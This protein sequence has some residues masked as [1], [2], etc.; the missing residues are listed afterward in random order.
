M[1]KQEFDTEQSD[2]C[3]TAAYQPCTLRP[4]SI[5]SLRRLEILPAYPLAKNDKTRRVLLLLSN[6]LNVNRNQ[7]ES[8][9]H[10]FCPFEFKEHR[11]VEAVDSFMIDLYRDLFI[12]PSQQWKI[13][14]SLIDYNLTRLRKCMQMYTKQTNEPALL[15]LNELPIAL[16]FF[17]QIDGK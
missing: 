3:S 17:L 2:G 7:F 14:Y 5:N 11:Y 1:E 10:G 16:E 13:P 9:S 12:E 6:V 4:R 8:E 15:S